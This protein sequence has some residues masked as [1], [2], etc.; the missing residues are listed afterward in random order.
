MFHIL[1]RVKIIFLY[2]DYQ[3]EIKQQIATDSH[4]VEGLSNRKHDN[5]IQQA[6]EWMHLGGGNPGMKYKH[7]ICTRSYKHL[8]RWHGKSVGD[9]ERS[10]SWDTIVN[11]K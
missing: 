8:I 7:I 6:V 11:S 10:E 1:A 4:L 2:I 9:M 5:D 3:L